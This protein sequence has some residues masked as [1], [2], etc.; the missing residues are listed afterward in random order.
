MEPK[1]FAALV[2]LLVAAITAALSYLKFITDKE[3]TT[4]AFRQSWI[5][6]VRSELAALVSAG[7]QLIALKQEEHRCVG[8]E[9]KHSDLARKPGIS[10][11]EKLAA[12][13]NRDFFEKSLL[14][15]QT[16]FYSANHDFNHRLYLCRLHF[17][18]DDLEANEIIDGI[19]TRIKEASRFEP[20]NDVNDEEYMQVVQAFFVNLDADLAVISDKCRVLLKNEW[21][22]VKNGEEVYATTRRYLGFVALAIGGLC[23]LAIALMWFDLTNPSVALENESKSRERSP[24]VTNIIGD[25]GCST[26]AS[27][28]S[29]RTASTRPATAESTA[30]STSTTTKSTNDA[31]GTASCAQK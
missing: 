22:R 15:V 31:V 12:E 20:S 24:V 3:N 19:Y 21:E 4:T 11:E 27:V 2:S 29:K 26:A 16:R 8:D 6:A 14:E 25:N 10:K 7:R 18:K 28:R 1:Y 9:K 23:A 5:I 30:E 13:K 17:K